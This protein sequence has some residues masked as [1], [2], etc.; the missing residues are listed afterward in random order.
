MEASE[1]Q[2]LVV[3]YGNQ[4]QTGTREGG[5]PLQESATAGTK[6]IHPAI[7]KLHVRKGPVKAFGKGAR[8]RVVKQYSL[9]ES[10]SL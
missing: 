9:L 5:Q 10:E 1:D 4:W 8:N 7:H 3:G 2:Y 6:L